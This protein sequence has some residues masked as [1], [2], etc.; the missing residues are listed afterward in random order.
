[1]DWNMDSNNARLNWLCKAAARSTGLMLS[2]LFRW[3][4]NCFLPAHQDHDP[5]LGMVIFAWS[6]GIRSNPILMGQILLGLIKNRVK[7]GFKKKNPKQ[8]RVGSGFYKKN[9]RP[10]PRL[11]PDKNPVSEITKIPYVYIYL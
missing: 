4:I 10:N 9:S 2:T 11:G 8:V 3:K 5:K 1:M 6:A 7:Y